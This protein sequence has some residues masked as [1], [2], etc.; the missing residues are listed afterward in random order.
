MHYS[1]SIGACETNFFFYKMQDLSRTPV[2]NVWYL[3]MPIFRRS[4]V[5]IIK[6]VSY[7]G[8]IF[9]TSKLAQLLKRTELKIHFIFE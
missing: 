8:W 5:D 6:E 3:G 1:S 4:H 2:H 7:G 9:D